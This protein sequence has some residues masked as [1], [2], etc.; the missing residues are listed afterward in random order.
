LARNQQA[1]DLRGVKLVA[2]SIDSVE[3]S[4]AMAQ[5]NGIKFP[6]LQDKD[7]VVAKQLVGID[8]AD[9]PI[10]GVILVAKGGNIVFRQIASS[11][12]DRIPTAQLLQIIDQKIGQAASS[13]S[14]NAP[15]QRVEVDQSFAPIHRLQLSTDLGAGIGRNASFAS[16]VTI[17]LSLPL[18]RRV[19][20]GAELAGSAH[21]F[22]TD[23]TFSAGA[24]L[25]FRSP[26]WN[27]L[28]ALHLTLAGGADVLQHRTDTDIY[29]RAAAQLWFAVRPTFAIQTGLTVDAHWKSSAAT[30]DILVT[31]GFARLFE[32]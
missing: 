12:D 31:I 32:L 20:I 13:N 23:A 9:L 14:G 15:Y 22:K 17:A 3:Q 28:A 7:A 5:K 16:Q 8:D 26:F 4:T 24:R 29:S 10:P 18:A 11:K 6:I 30:R 19:V 2:I 25:T 1:F 27:D 21:P